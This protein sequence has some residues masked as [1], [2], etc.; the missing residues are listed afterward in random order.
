M[1][2]FRHRCFT[3]LFSL[4]IS[5]VVV[6]LF[7]IQVVRNDYYRALA[8]QEHQRVLEIY[9]RRGQIFS[10]DHFPLVL[11]NP[12]YL[13]YI[14]PKKIKASG[15]VAKTL[16]KMLNDNEASTS[17]TKYDQKELQ[18]KMDLDLDWVAIAK[19]LSPELKGKIMNLNIPGLGFD[20]ETIRF[21][22]EGTTASYV[23]G[24]V[25]ENE[26]G[27]EQGYYGLEGYYQ[28]EL[29]GRT[30]KV[31]EETAAS[32]R[33][34]PI[35]D[36]RQVVAEDGADL[37]L[38]INREVQYL[39]ETKLE[40]AVVKYGARLATAIVMDPQSGAIVGLASYPNYDATHF[41]DLLKQQET[42]A[43]T[44]SGSFFRNPAISE[45]YEPGSVIKGLTMAAALDTN[46]VKPSSTFEDSGPVTVSGFTV[47]NWN[48]QHYGT[49]TMIELL[50][51]SNNIGA[52]YVGRLLGAKVLREY[53]VKFGLGSLTGIDLEGE[54]TGVLKKEAD[55]REIDVMTAAF[56]QG[57]SATPLQ[58][59]TAY[60]VFANG[61]FS[62]RPYIVA[63][64]SDNRGV[65]TLKSSEK[66][67]V[68]SP[69]TAA[70][71][72]EMLTAAAEGGE[73]KFT[74]L[75]RYRVAGK[76]GTA[77]IPL[78]GKYDPNKTEATFVGFLT[79]HPQFVLLVKI[80]EPSSSI[81]AAETAAPVWMD[82][83]K[84]LTITY[85]IPPDR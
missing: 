81:Y 24:F 60:A 22:P 21:Y 35:G 52:T 55:W 44:D 51:K 27:E 14:E 2:Y 74:I 45:S 40:Q 64:I 47:D 17:G 63:E 70:T 23:F 34:I 19:H 62:V 11:N 9:P 48:Y 67:K 50:Q 79:N 6:R 42:G 39:L 12:A 82:L 59:L 13:L 73:A 71:M 69:E 68:I 32:G 72:V 10:A 61:G 41:T 78:G 15:E 26:R 7:Y 37:T 58:V 57:L 65:R 8:E 85:R 43:N 83:V 18:A 20:E 5:A 31:F 54:A 4:V 56:G 76:T 30:G 80:S 28:G 29:K 38:T 16:A 49:Q 77:Q 1:S 84:N 36:Y 66:K 53:F 46:A 33:P 3:F 25:G 75:K